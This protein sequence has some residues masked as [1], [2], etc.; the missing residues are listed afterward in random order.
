MAQ[1]LVED[2]LWAV[3]EPLLPYHTPSPLG[4]RPRASDRAALTGIVFVLRSGIPWEYL[5]PDLGCNA[6]TCWRRLQEWQRDGVFDRVLEC[7]LVRLHRAGKLDWS[8]AVID[9]AQAPAKRGGAH[10][11]PNPTDRGKRGSKHH[12]IADRR[13]IPLATPILT[14]SNVPDVVMLIPLVDHVNPVRGRVG[15]PRRRPAKLHADKGYSSRANRQALR[16]RGI[17]PRI[18]RPP[19]SQARGSGVIDGLSNGRWHGYTA[20]DDCSPD[21]NVALKFTKASSTWPQFSSAGMPSNT[22]SGGVLLGALT[23]ERLYTAE[24]IGAKYGITADEVMA[25]A[26]GLGIIGDPRY[27]KWVPSEPPPGTAEERSGTIDGDT[28]SRPKVPKD[29]CG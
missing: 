4:G 23:S 20:F 12:I 3:F 1:H 24:E 28:P 10:T 16:Q 14:A 2:E 29:S 27:G 15:H 26:G 6:M 25:I 7:L 17:Q 18:A 22:E 11:G 13:G 19:S 8:R 9:S 5:P 21:M